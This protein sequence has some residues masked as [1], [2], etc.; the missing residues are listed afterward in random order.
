MSCPNCPNRDRFVGSSY[1]PQAKFA[2]VGTAP[3]LKDRAG[4]PFTG[5]A[6]KDFNDTLLPSIGID[7]SEITMCN[8]VGCYWEDQS[9][10]PLE[11]AKECSAFH[12]PHIVQNA[13]VVAVMGSLA[14]RVVGLD[15]ERDHGISRVA[16][17]EQWGYCGIVVPTLHPA[18]TT[19]DPGL[20]G[21]LKADFRVVKAALQGDVDEQVDEYPDP[22]CTVLT[23]IEEIARYPRNEIPAIDT[24]WDENTGKPVCL[25]YSFDPRF[26]RLIQAGSDLLLVFADFINNRYQGKILLHNQGEDL[27]MLAKMGIH[28]DPRRVI[29]TMAMA[30]HLGLPQ[31]LKDLAWRLLRM[32]WSSYNELVAPYSEDLIAEWAATALDAV[33]TA[34]PPQLLSKTGKPIKKPI[35]H[36]VVKK[37]EALLDSKATLFEYAERISKWKPELLAQFKSV[38]TTECPAKSIR[39]VPLD[40]MLQYACM[41]AIAT[42]RVYCA[43][44]NRKLKVLF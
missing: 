10:I 29:D 5:W 30:Y 18:Q 41:D 36:P 25:T 31:S 23:D 32:E 7:R 35:H 42:G 17:I 43:L 39:H 9:K 12:L 28:I 19:H 27:A 16:D 24:E 21:E 13:P 34:F 26:G 44:K 3:G 37:F 40:K 15:A 33:Q 1:N 6:A 11:L 38:V 2:C 20:L 8:V 14:N 4:K 22:V